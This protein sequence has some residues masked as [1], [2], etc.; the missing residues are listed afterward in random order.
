[1][2]ATSRSTETAAVPSNTT[3]TV[4]CGHNLVKK[5]K[6]HINCDNKKKQN[7]VMQHELGQSLQL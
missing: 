2:M 6:V 7:E 4:Q 5:K 3:P 1:M